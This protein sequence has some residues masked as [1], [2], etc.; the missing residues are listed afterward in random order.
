MKQMQMKTTASLILIILFSSLLIA[1]SSADTGTYRITDYTVTLA[2]KLSGEIAMDYS[3]T[4]LVTGGNIP[5]VTVGLPNSNYQI[6]GWGGAAKKVSNANEGSWYGAR[7]D[8]DRNYLPNERFTYNFSIVQRNLMESRSDGY[9]LE[10]TPGWYDRAAIDKMSI[11]VISPIDIKNATAS[12]D[13]ASWQGRT[14]IFSKS[15]LPMGEKYKVSVKFPKN[16][17]FYVQAKPP[18]STQ[19]PPSI[20][21]RLFTFILVLI[22]VAVMFAIDYYTKNDDDGYWDYGGPIIYSGHKSGGSGGG[23]NHKT[24]GS[25]GFGGRSSSCA[26]VSC[27]CACA[28]ACA[29]GGGGGG[30]G[31]A[32]K[33]LHFCK[34]CG[35]QQAMNR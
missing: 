20:W 22:F 17:P 10:F 27:A 4:W 26:C 31:C 28:C 3:Q 1:G 23:K 16:A 30:A 25:G 15:N 35:D 5:W 12:P 9:W 2:P 21:N 19:S 18:Q 33:W 13:P 32:K 7:I 29:G 24:G 11:K 6:K 8:L 34:K 14:L